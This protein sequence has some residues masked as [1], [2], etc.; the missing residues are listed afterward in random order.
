MKKLQFQKKQSAHLFSELHVDLSKLEN[1][2]KHVLMLM[3]REDLCE[4]EV[5]K[6][7]KFKND[8]YYSIVQC[9]HSTLSETKIEN[10][11]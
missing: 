8:F 2:N 9:I 11:N 1:V 5:I 3:K 7:K 10:E 6:K 4:N